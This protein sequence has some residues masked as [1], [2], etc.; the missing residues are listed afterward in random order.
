MR[1]RST[2][3]LCLPASLTISLAVAGAAPRPALAQSD[4]DRATARALGQEGE[5]A[6]EARDFK[7]AEDRFR[8]ADRLVHAPTLELGL[9][10]AL[11]ANGKYVESQ[12]TYNRIIR[13]G[14]A[15]GAPEAF[16]K[17]LEDAKREVDTVAPKVSGVTITVQAAGG[18]DVSSA[19]ITIDDQPMN[20]AS[21]GVRR[22]IDPGAHVL[23]VMV[24]GFKPAE[25]RFTVPDGGSVSEPVTLEKDLSAPAAGATPA[26]TAPATT[27][28]PGASALA[29][30]NGAP[31]ASAGAGTPE[32]PASGGGK[33]ALPWV[34]FGVGGAG[35]VVGAVTGAMALGKHSDLSNSCTLPN[36]GCPTAQQDSLNSYHTL[37]AVSTVGF[38]VGGVGVV[39]GVVLL[40]TQPKGE[41]APA[42]QA[43]GLHVV[44]VVGPG[45]LGAFGSF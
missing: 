38:I 6:L 31:A 26:A 36:N 35:L 27:G 30:S 12:E 7:T 37:G 1:L 15:P 32:H 34:A 10:R 11:A 21:L 16:R 14:V 39:A 45:S 33:S 24:D 18:G 41:S 8:R 44:P 29:G 43:A 3:T 20:T 23:R 13:E 19:K 2:L 40:L 42:P 5:Q 25:E 9:A 17:A 28:A 4:S 22:L